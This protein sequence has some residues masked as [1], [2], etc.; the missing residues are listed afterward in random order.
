MEKKTPCKTGDPNG[1]PVHLSKCLLT[2]RGLSGPATYM[3]SCSMMWLGTSPAFLSFHSFKTCR[4]DILIGVSS[5]F[6]VF[7]PI[8]SLMSLWMPRSFMSLW[9]SSSLTSWGT[10]VQVSCIWNQY[11]WY[12]GSFPLYHHSKVRGSSTPL[13][14]SLCSLVHGDISS[15]LDSLYR[16]H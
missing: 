3:P 4:L 16:L 10:Y 1:M 12:G 15:L 11:L 7:L 5:G 2:V 9:M 6:K 8:L 14:S 13:T